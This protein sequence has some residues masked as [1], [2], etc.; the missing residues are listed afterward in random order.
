MLF[1]SQGTNSTYVRANTE[2]GSNVGT[3][4]I[5][6]SRGNILEFRLQ[7]A[8]DV[9]TSDYLFNQLGTDETANYTGEITGYE[10][11]NVRHV[12]GSVRVTGMTT[13]AFVEIPILLVKKIS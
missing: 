2:K 4:V 13:G 12:L 6:G 11:N 3:E 1:R 8:L 10:G 9:A 7:A 5:A